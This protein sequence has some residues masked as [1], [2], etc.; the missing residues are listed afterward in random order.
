MIRRPGIGAASAPRHPDGLALMLGGGGA[1]GAYQA[2]VLHGIA[3]RFPDLRFPIM[4]GI[5]AGAI[6]TIHLASRD[7]SLR[8][9]TEELVEL[10]LQLTPERVYDVRA[11]PL[12]R[13]V[14]RWSG[15]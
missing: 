7:V 9:A 13:N 15:R 6:N 11:L 10:W 3:R 2:G 14:V 1:R 8:Q 4:T 5:S 12:F